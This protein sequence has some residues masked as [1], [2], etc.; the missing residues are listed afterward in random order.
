MTKYYFTADL[1]LDHENIIKY[2]GRP[3]KSLEEMNKKLIKNW[4]S[5]VKEKDTIFHVGDFCFKGRKAEHWIEQLNGRIIFIK[6]N[7]DINNDVKSIV[8]NITIKHGGMKILLIHCAREAEHIEDFDFVLSAHVHEKW[9]H[10][11]YNGTLLINVGVDQWNFRP[12]TINEILK[13]RNKILKAP[14]V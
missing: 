3:F 13:Y 10:R 2:T 6:G 11:Y 9:K 7:H 4:N 1:H 14:L 12:I 8:D 5:R